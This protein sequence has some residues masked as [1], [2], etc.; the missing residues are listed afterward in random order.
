MTSIWLSIDKLSG[1]IVSDHIG[2]G[3]VNNLRSW[4]DHN[5]E[6]IL[7]KGDIYNAHEV[8]RKLGLMGDF[9]LEQCLRLAYRK[10]GHEFLGW[11]DGSFL[12]AV[13][14]PN[15]NR[16][17]CG[18]D[19]LGS[20][21][22]Y[23]SEDANHLLLDNDLLK[24]VNGSSRVCG[25]NH[26]AIYNYY[27]FNGGAIAPDTFYDGISVLPAGHCLISDGPNFEICSTR[28]FSFGTS[29]K[30]T[31]SDEELCHDLKG[32]IKRSI[33]NCIN[34]HGRVGFAVSGGLDS[35]VIAAIGSKNLLSDYDID[36]F[37]ISVDSPD[38]DESII[39]SEIV[40]AIGGKHYS[41]TISSHDVRDNIAAIIDC[42]CEPFTPTAIGRWF[43]YQLVSDAGCSNLVEGW[44]A[45]Q[46]FGGYAEHH[47][48]LVIS[49]F[50]QCKYRDWW[51]EV[52]RFGQSKIR[53]ACMSAIKG[54]LINVNGSQIAK[55][56]SWIRNIF[57]SR[58]DNLLQVDGSWDNYVN[59][60]ADNADPSI[61]GLYFD[62]HMSTSLLVTSLPFS[63]STNARNAY[64]H[65]VKTIFPF[66]S[67]SV[68][69]FALAL[70]HHLIVHNGAGKIALRQAMQQELPGI[71]SNKV[72][73]RGLEIPIG[74][75]LRGDLKFVMERLLDVDTELVSTKRMHTIV[76]RF[77]A[78]DIP[79]NDRIWRMFIIVYFEYRLRGID[80][81]AN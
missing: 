27:H 15:K 33:S 38:Y 42:H 55:F 10:V 39:Q 43:L 24:V 12:V 21:R 3:L 1:I 22:L 25:L 78:G 69:R 81:V 13:L 54:T 18:A 63:L 17:I 67:M 66:L 50:A 62:E 7:I 76:S 71:L 11:F 48:A 56:S 68:A 35:A 61:Y 16:I 4:R 77:L 45:D 2:D 70:P 72:S 26:Q 32:L 74:A 36:C 64:A 57:S 73:K 37:S 60:I 80:L 52:N 14:D 20:M 23:F 34:S 79:Y 58:G 59:S 65:N 53:T 41:K 30:Q 47:N 5:D 31:A 6:I 51:N 28:Y 40:N 46:L 8:A 9:N 29:M 44:G 19:P 49:L 75:W